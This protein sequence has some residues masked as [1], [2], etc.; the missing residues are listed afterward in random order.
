MDKKE[1]EFQKRILAT[2]RIEADEHI[3]TILS[4]LTILEKSKSEKEKS[5]FIE[6][7]FRE[8]HSLKGAARSVD[9]KEIESVCQPMETIFSAIK[10]KE[11]ALTPDVFDLFYKT[12]E[13][14][15]KYTLTIG[16][17]MTQAFRKTQKELI[18]RMDEISSV[19]TISHETT[20]NSTVFMENAQ[21]PEPDLI[22]SA[23]QT[24]VV[25]SAGLQSQSGMVRIPI[26][27]LD[28]LLLEAEEMLQSKIAVDQRVNDLKMVCN[29]LNDWKTETVKW[30]N[31]RANATIDMWR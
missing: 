7:L 16:T 17:S 11:L 3:H 26:S 29:E 12:M 28:P 25:Q 6:V 8:F 27:K 9:Q 20:Q 23:E 21:V 15:S 4:G 2:F 22:P 10:R 14:L 1:E 13:W 18:T 19:K 30:K 5:E 31:L 24:A